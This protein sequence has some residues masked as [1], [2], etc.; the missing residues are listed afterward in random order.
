[1][2]AGGAV[3]VNLS[4]LSFHITSVHGATSILKSFHSLAEVL[5]SFFVL[6]LAELVV[7]LF[8]E[9]CELLLELGN[10]GI[11]EG[12]CGAVGSCLVLR[13]GLGLLFF[14]FGLLRSGLWLFNGS[15]LGLFNG[16][17]LRFLDFVDRNR[18]WLGR[19]YGSSSCGCGLGGSWSCL[20]TLGL[21]LR[22]VWE[23]KIVLVRD[24]QCTLILFDVLL[25]TLD[26]LLCLLVHGLELTNAHQVDDSVFEL[27]SRFIGKTSTQVRFDQHVHIIDVE[28]AVEHL[29]AEI[30]LHLV[31][32]V[33]T[34]AESNVTEDGS[35][36]LCD[37]FLENTEVFIGNLEDL[38]RIFIK[39][40]GLSVCAFFEFELCL[41][42]SDLDFSLD[43]VKLRLQAG[44]LLVVDRRLRALN[45]LG[46][47][48]DRGRLGGLSSDRGGLGGLSSGSGSLLVSLDALADLVNSL[49]DLLA[50]LL[51]LRLLLLQF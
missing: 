15:R 28:R 40:D 46:L 34:I 8:L 23:G 3:G 18:H 30:D 4:N 50:H 27:L 32:L 7:T 35:L 24:E 11:R 2:Q 48:C 29:G 21:K 25:A 10:I 12:W 20:S 44:L 37:L 36:H 47:R 22:E 49:V 26:T 39:F 42:L 9:C 38:C 19:L 13:G 45:R 51:Q 43:L 1:V 17:R 31:L 33:L 6:L 16:S 5:N 14:F 41:L